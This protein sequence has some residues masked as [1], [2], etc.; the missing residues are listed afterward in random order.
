MVQTRGPCWVRN[1]RW[2]V[3]M[4]RDGMAEAAARRANIHGNPSG[5]GEDE[6]LS[7]IRRQWM[8]AAEGWAKWEPAISA[9]MEPATTLM[10][11]MAGVRPGVTV[12]DVA[13]GAG[14]QTMQAAIRV[15]P[16][17]RVVAA[18][19]AEPMLAYVQARAE[20]RGLS[21][22][23]T[24]AGAAEELD[25]EP[26]SLDA[27]ICRLGLMLFARPADALRAVR[28]ALRPGGRL[29]LVV[30]TT[31]DANPFMSRSLE[32]VRR[33][34]GAA[35]PPPG[36]PG[37]FS[38]GAPGRLEG[39]LTASG[40]TDI[41]QRALPVTLRSRTPERMLTMMQDAFGV[42]RAV[43]ASCTEGVREAAW[44]EVGAFLETFDTPEGFAAPG[45]VWVTAGAASAGQ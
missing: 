13:C 28:A 9:W 22:V 25:L 45:E 1:F 33:H 10:L 32:I 21:N 8:S 31:P 36:P 11:D 2:G 44:A 17:G 24:M 19:L 20:E 42:Y 34:A 30:F 7:A 15:G 14:D 37:L 5:P 41:E 35:P 12:L 43:L 40:F 23:R 26:A 16:E 27:C 18:D 29:A 38:L 39:M 4:K 3:E 6:A